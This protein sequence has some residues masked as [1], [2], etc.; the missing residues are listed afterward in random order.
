[1]M[2]IKIMPQI[3]AVDIRNYYYYHC[4]LHWLTTTVAPYNNKYTWTRTQYTFKIIIVNSDFVLAVAA[5]I[6]INFPT[7]YFTIGM[8]F[9]GCRRKWNKSTFVVDAA[10]VLPCPTNIFVLLFFALIFVWRWRLIDVIIIVRNAVIPTYL[11]AS[12]SC[13]MFYESWYVLHWPSY[14]GCKF[15][16]KG[17]CVKPNIRG[18]I[19]I[20]LI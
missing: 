6:E 7:K 20:N 2:R 4:S 16:S 5:Y 14:F 10:S 9:C 15:P 13:F 8:G 18:L 17:I 11:Y 3:C 1:M 12:C 19:R